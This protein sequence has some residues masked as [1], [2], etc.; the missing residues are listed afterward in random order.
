MN[1]SK[2][3]NTNHPL[4][5]R[6]NLESSVAMDAYTKPSGPLP[7][8]NLQQTSLIGSAQPPASNDIPQPVTN[9]PSKFC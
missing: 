8:L 7:T 3:Y 9:Y 1:E 5:F 6:T 2:D 4:R